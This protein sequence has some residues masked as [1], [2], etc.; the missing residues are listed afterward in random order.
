[1]IETARVNKIEMNY[2]HF[3]RGKNIMVILPGLSFMPV[4]I[5]EKAIEVAFADFTDEYTVYLF[6]C[7]TDIPDNYSVNGMA[8]DTAAVMES[9]GLENAC[10]FGASLGGMV[11]QTIA[12]N[13]P[14]LIRKMVLASTLS[15]ANETISALMNEWTS[16]ADNGKTYE[17]NELMCRGIYGREIMEKYGK[18]LI[19]MGSTIPEENSRRFVKLGRTISKFDVFD[20]LGE[21]RCDVLVVGSEGDKVITPESIRETAEVLGCEIYMYGDEYGH[22]VYDEAPD[23][24]PRMLE[25]FMR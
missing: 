6:D 15:K 4:T 5:S 16:L 10:V 8:E 19:A 17:A 2:I 24:R 18:G 23:F 11:A 3:G 20:R 22:A 21:I 1:M 9:L 14:H 7:V 12:L 13:Y 25:F